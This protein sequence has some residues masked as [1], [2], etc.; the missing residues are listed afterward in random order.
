MDREAATSS[1]ERLAAIQSARG[2]VERRRMFG[3]DG[4]TIGGRFFAFLDQDRLL[5]K[6]PQAKMDA[7]LAEGHATS[8]VS[9]SPTMTKWVAIPY[10]S[11]AADW[12][13]LMDEARQFVSQSAA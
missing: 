10:A 9:V 5:L 3:H 1:F 13:A 4:L 12:E 8:A 7:L 6:L 2:D 11:R